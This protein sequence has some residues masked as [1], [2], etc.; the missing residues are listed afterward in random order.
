MR[1]LAILMLMAA[2]AAHAAEAPAWCTAQP[3]AGAVKSMAADAAR[4]LPGSPRAI[5]RIHVEGTLPHQGIW[6]V[7]VEAKKDLHLMRDLALLWRANGDKATLAQLAALLDAWADVYQ[8]A[9]NPIDETDFDMLVDAYAVTQAALPPATRAKVAAMLHGWSAGYLREMANPHGWSGIWVNNW[10]SH[11]I[12]LATLMA[13]AL[14]DEDLYTAARAE[15][16]KQLGRNLR[17]DGG[18]IDFEERDALHYTVYDLEPL[19]RAAMAARLRGEDWLHLSGDN[20]ATLAKAL[21][22]LLPYA[23]GDKVHEEYVHT[24]V[25]FDLQRRDAGLPGYAG[26]WDPKNSTGLYWLAATLDSRYAPVARKLGPQPVWLQ[27]C[28]N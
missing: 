7:S 28:W 5:P 1:A 12:K 3:S 23:G 20:G 16:K 22:W 6:D 24:K 27:A 18:T 8:P 10:Q 25:K 11:R 14:K 15:F 9:Y 13:V 2:G 4:L 26:P 19:V 21:D 17:A